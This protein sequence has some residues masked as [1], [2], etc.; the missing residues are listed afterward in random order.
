[1]GD[2]PYV[3]KN[4]QLGESIFQAK[5]DANGQLQMS[6]W[7]APPNANFLYKHDLDFN[8]SPIAL[9]YSGR[10]FLLETSKECRLYLLDRD[11]MGGGEAAEHRQSLDQSDLACNDRQAFDAVGVWGSMAAYVNPRNEAWVYMPFWGPK[12]ET[13]NPPATY[14]PEPV[15]GGVA[16]YSISQVN[17]KWKLVPKWLS[18]DINV[19]EEA[20]IANDIVFTYGSG[21]DPHQRAVD[22]SWDKPAKPGSRIE[23]GTHATL[24]ALDAQTGKTLW[25]SGDQITS[26]NHFSGITVANGRIYLG[27][28]DGTMWCFGIEKQ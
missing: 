21:E 17:G 6:G 2:A 14:K 28:F 24:Y 4:R 3:P 8:V 23:K 5:P 11:N 25:S 19:G 18:E 7:F 16:A 22:T 27:T 12:S 1:V 13:F 20:L 9:D 15:R 26:W 10:K